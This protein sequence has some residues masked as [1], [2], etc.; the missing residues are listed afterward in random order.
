M[1][2]TRFAVVLALTCALPRLAAAEDS[3]GAR[4]EQVV[5]DQL[6]AYDRRDVAAT[7]AYVHTKSPDYDQTR[8]AITS[9]F[10]QQKVSARLESFQ[11]IG[12]DDEFAVARVKVKVTAPSTADFTDN[13]VDSI[14]LFHQED[15]T[16]KIWDDYA[17]G[18]QTLE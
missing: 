3:L 16:W 17:L 8:E 7:L 9:Q 13:I 6:A 5:K 10:A 11:Y 18:I 15:G 2:A 12:H 1:K 4:L 14:T